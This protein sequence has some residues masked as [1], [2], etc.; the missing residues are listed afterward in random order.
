M[1]HLE[2][3]RILTL[4]LA[5]AAPSGAAWAQGA[6]A[7]HV[8][9]SIP[10]VLRLRLDDGHAAADAPVDV[11]V[12]T[13]AGVTTID[14]R[15]TRVAVRANTAWHLDARFHAALG[16]EALELTGRLEYGPSLDLCDGAR[17]ASGDANRDWTVFE[18]TYGVAHVLSNG[19]YSGTVV[20]TLTRP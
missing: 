3:W 6:A 8:S 16:S 10:V 15:T 1:R 17:L 12:R 2:A 7:H 18:V 19:R 4:T 20:Y 5:L 9:V 13:R 11:L 14:P